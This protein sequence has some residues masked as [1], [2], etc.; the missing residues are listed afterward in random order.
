MDPSNKT[1]MNLAEFLNSTKNL[2]IYV[3]PANDRHLDFAGQNLTIFNKF[4]NPLEIS[5]LLE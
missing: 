2:L 3:E 1:Q 4:Y 5:P